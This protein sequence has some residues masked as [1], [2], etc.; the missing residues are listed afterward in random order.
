MTRGGVTAAAGLAVVAALV[1]A[2]ALRSGAG[3]GAP[4]AGAH[5]GAGL[6]GYAGSQRCM[7]CHPI[8]GR[9]WKESLHARTVH[10]PSESERELLSRALLCGEEEAVYVL[11]ERHSRRF[12]TPSPSEPGRHVLLP[13]RYDVGPAEWV[14]LHEGDWK[15]LTW[16]KGC[17][18][19]HSVGFSSADFSLKEMGVGC[20]SCHG[21]DQRHGNHTAGAGMLAFRSLSPKEEVTVC[22]SCHLQGGKSAS[23]GLNYARDYQAGGDLFSDYQFDWSALDKPATEA[24]N[25]ID[26]HQKLLIRDAVTRGRDDLRCTSCHEFHAMG[27]AK[28]QKLARQEFCHL[29]HERTDFR[30]KEYS[31]SCNVCEF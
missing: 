14:G 4:G 9:E 23:T 11:G 5:A 16:E 27:H 30:L 2:W 3:R 15:T 1:V 26:V 20:E 21:P 28:H 13:C 25:P 22:A 18:A 17:G 8:Q 31:Q 24:D 10:P 7:Q 12:M 19:C 29:C 6:T